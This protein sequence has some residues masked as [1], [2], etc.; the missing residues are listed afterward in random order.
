MDDIR[1]RKISVVMA[2]L[3]V[4]SASVEVLVTVVDSVIVDHVVEGANVVVAATE[5]VFVTV[6]VSKSKTKVSHMMIRG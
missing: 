5:A 4:A 1:L 2:R 3:T 6:A